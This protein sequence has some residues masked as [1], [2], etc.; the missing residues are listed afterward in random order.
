[1]HQILSNFDLHAA[2]LFPVSQQRFVVK[3]GETC[4]ESKV[5]PGA[6]LHLES[7]FGSLLQKSEEQTIVICP[8]QP[9]SL[10]SF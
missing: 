5:C 4:A 2:S 3:I 6:A 10:C 8:Q 7:T 1:M 9:L